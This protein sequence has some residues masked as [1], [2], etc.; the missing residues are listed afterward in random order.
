MINLDEWKNISP[1]A[2]NSVS[3]AQA[4]ARQGQLTKPPGSLGKLEALAI[5]LAAMQGL[6]CPRSDKVSITIFAADHGIAQQKVSAFPQEVTTQMVLN[7]AEGGAVISV[8]A[9]QLNCDF[10]V[11]NLGTITPIEHVGVINSII[12]ESTADFSCKEAMSNL[13]L[14]HSLNAG[15]EAVKRAI[16]R[17][18]ELFVAGEMGIAN[19]TSASA[20]MAAS[21]QLSGSKVAGPGT[22]VADVG[23]KHKAEVIDRAILLHKAQLNSPLDILRC[24][25]GFEIAAMVGAYLYSAEQGLACIV[26]G[27]ISTVA[28]YLA[29]QINAGVIKWMIFG[30]QSSEPFHRHILDLLNAEPLLEL[31]M[32]LGEGSGAAVAINILRVACELHGNVATFSGAGVSQ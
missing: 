11:V 18:A 17:G 20:I 4:E 7:F 13:Q 22:G 6:E 3:K 19:T 26:D 16:N 1:A 29:I 28:A 9:R 30:H 2:L 12:A 21:L 10:D 31:G 32:R 27:F 5:R 25:G 24:L 15:A 23:I 14:E 8:L